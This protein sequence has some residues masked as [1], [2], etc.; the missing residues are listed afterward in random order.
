MK[1]PSQEELLGYMLGALDAQEHE[2][3]QEF[4]DQDSNLEEKLL[5]IKASLAP[6]ELVD[7][8]TGPPPGLARRCCQFV[9][10]R[11]RHTAH[12]DLTSPIVSTNSL[13]RNTFGKSVALQCDD[14]PEPIRGSRWSIMD[15]VFACT[16][17]MLVGALLLPALSMA[18]FNSRVTACQSNMRSLFY[19]LVTYASNHGGRFVE[20]P[21]DGPLARAG[22]FGPILKDNGLIDDDKVFSCPGTAAVSK[23][24]H[25]PSCD[26]IVSADCEIQRRNYQN[27]MSGDYG[28]SL[29]YLDDGKYVSPRNAGLSN[30]VLVADAPSCNTPNRVSRNHGGRGQNCLMGCGG[31]QYNRTG[32]IGS[33]AI[34]V[35]DLNIVAPGVH[36]NDVVI[37][38]SHIQIFPKQGAVE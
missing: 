18:R 20:I 5:A 11:V 22:C 27:I 14:Y 35:N 36:A 12:C 38:P 10:S 23:T 9:A 3:I 25:I 15:L 26:E 24:V 2:Q 37:A 29:G 30:I 6:L 21:H 28:Y 8:P 31:I 33:D 13:N 16:A 4:I 32:V 1:Q 7:D 19:S 17:A 34:F